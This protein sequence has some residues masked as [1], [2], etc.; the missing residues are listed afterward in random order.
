[1]LNQGTMVPDAPGRAIQGATL[2]GPIQGQVGGHVV[3]FLLAASRAIDLLNAWI[4]KIATATVLL[5]VLISAGNA[6]VRYAFN[7]S[8]NAW[9][10]IQWYLFA[11]MVM[12][13]ASYTLAKNG[14]VRVDILYGNVSQRTQLWI[15]LIGT[16]VFLLP[17]TIIIGWVS[18]PLFYNS[19]LIGEISGNANGLIRWPVKLV[20][21]VGFFSL[22][23]QGISEII[24]RIAALVGHAERIE[25]Y[26]KPLQ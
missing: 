16:I 14:H 3:R 12:F 19:Y 18:W 15:D 25:H 20:L 11:V 21:P 6:T 26:E 7:I 1:M 5:C 17:A 2:S 23:L 10:E 8:S 9:L 13:G 4:G 22:T 24:K